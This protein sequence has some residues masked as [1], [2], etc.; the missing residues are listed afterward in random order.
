[1]PIDQ[2]TAVHTTIQDS[3]MNE[4][5]TIAATQFNTDLSATD[6]TVTSTADFVVGCLVSVQDGTDVLQ[7]EDGTADLILIDVI[8]AN[9]YGFIR[10]IDGGSTLTISSTNNATESYCT[11]MTLESGAI[12]FDNT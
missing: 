6:H 8:D 5:G 10:S 7:I 2:A 9:S 1:M 11:A 4:A 12:T 3:Q